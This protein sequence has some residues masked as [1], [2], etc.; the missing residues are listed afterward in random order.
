MNSDQIELLRKRKDEFDSFYQSLIPSLVEFVGLLG[1]SPAH[2]VLKNA[3][4]FVPLLGRATQ[5][6]AVQGQEDRMWPVTRMAYFIGEVFVQRFSGCWFVDELPDTRYFA[7]YVVGKFGAGIR[8]NAMI[9]PFEISTA[10]VDGAL[11]RNL[12]GLINEVELAVVRA[13]KVSSPTECESSWPGFREYNESVIF[14][15]VAQSEPLSVCLRRSL[16]FHA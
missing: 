3:E 13:L 11:P 5:D 1:I 10:Y 12:G 6:M 4:Q 7:H 8:T 14:E 2:E 9:D 15:R 16:V